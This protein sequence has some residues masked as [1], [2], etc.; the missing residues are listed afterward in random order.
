MKNKD[1]KIVSGVLKKYRGKDSNVIIPNG[2]EK[3]GKK[4]FKGCKNITSI[5]ISDDVT[6]IE[7]YAFYKCAS[8]KS[9]TFGKSAKII[10]TYSFFN[11][12]S[13]T[14]VT[15]E[16]ESLS[17]PF[18]LYDK[19]KKSNIKSILKSINSGVFFG[20]NK[21]KT[22]KYGKH[23][24]NIDFHIFRNCPNIEEYIVDEKNVFF[25]SIYGVIYSM[26]KSKLIKYPIGKKCDNFV[27]PNYVTEVSDRAFYGCKGLTTVTIES[28]S[29]GDYAFCGC[30]ELKSVKFG[31]GV[32]KIGTHAFSDCK[33]LAGVIIHKDIKEI[34][35]HAFQD[36]KE[37]RELT[38]E[39]ESIGD[40][41]FYGCKGLKSIKIGAGVKEIGENAFLYCNGEQAT[42]TISDGVEKIGNYAFK[43]F[44]GLKE[45][46]IESGSIGDRAFY[47]CKGLKSIKIGA[48]VKEIGE[49]AFLYCNGE[50]VTLTISDGVEKI[51]KYAFK[52]FNGLKEIT[53]ES[54]SIGDRA[55]YGCKGL[56]TVT[57][58]SGSI[59]DRAFYG[60]DALKTIRL[61]KNVSE[62]NEYAFTY[63]AYG[64]MSSIKCFC[65]AS[66]KP[67]SWHNNWINSN[68][69]IT[70]GVDISKI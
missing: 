39:S 37:I 55:F 24:R 45:I 6:E 13:L 36:C 12:E 30:E 48:G 47:G 65:E 35:A 28:E 67:A 3:I 20:C 70:W 64:D 50:Q 23:V 16:S 58:E 44:N 46:T 27:V 32:K 69:S 63:N 10:N 14:E 40:Y 62:I 57:I 29:I 53:I 8:L 1:F 49:N 17:N 21:L 9:V 51:G 56:T 61:G 11:C 52:E 18:V 26:D 54:G 68:V 22:V 38:I 2:V 43:E 42:L 34:G 7:E 25:S 5:I 4:A 41:A 66:E 31:N 59:G 33:K 19:Y 60:C 15:I